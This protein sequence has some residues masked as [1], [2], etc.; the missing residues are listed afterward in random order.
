MDELEAM[1]VGEKA[2]EL[3]S[4]VIQ[5]IT[6]APISQKPAVIRG[7]IARLQLFLSVVENKNDN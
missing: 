5:Q 2:N 3:A 6:E 4:Q 1:V 7:I